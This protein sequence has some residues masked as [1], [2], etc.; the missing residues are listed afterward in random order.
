MFRKTCLC[1]LFYRMTS[2]KRGLMPTSLRD[3]PI[4]AGDDACH[5]MRGDVW[6]PRIVTD[7]LVVWINSWCLLLNLLGIPSITSPSKAVGCCVSLVF[8]LLLTRCKRTPLRNGFVQLC[9]K[10]VM[11][12][13]SKRYLAQKMSG[14]TW[15]LLFSTTGLEIRE[16]ASNR[17][18]LCRIWNCI[19]TMMMMIMMFL[20]MMIIPIFF[21]QYHP[22]NST[23]ICLYLLALFFLFCPVVFLSLYV[24]LSLL[25]G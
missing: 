8:W 23:I 12:V 20:V 2:Q 4:T 11:K 25:H 21:F 17:T 19:M 7:Q 6:M 15:L 22:T 14:K 18:P 10:R 24:S 13:S 1:V 16:G 3:W 9:W 5:Q